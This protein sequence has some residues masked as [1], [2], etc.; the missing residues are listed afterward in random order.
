MID[1]LEVIKPDAAHAYAALARRV[2]AID[3]ALKC[4]TSDDVRGIIGIIKTEVEAAMDVIY[5]F[6]HPSYLSH[7]RQNDCKRDCGFNS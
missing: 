1:T 7:P 4:T 5:S 2:A 3:M 6:E